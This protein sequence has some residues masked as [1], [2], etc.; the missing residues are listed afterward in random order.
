[1]P[2]HLS[3]EDARMPEN[4]KI[5]AVLRRLDMTER[6]QTDFAKSL[7]TV[8]GDL[9]ELRKP[10][11]ELKTDKA[12]RAERDKNLHER[13]ERMENTIEK[14]LD[15]VKADIDKRFGR[16]AKPVWAAALAFISVLVG[17]VATFIIKGGLNV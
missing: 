6:N 5:D 11:D 14:G 10:L 4:E 1:M 7:T 2:Y 16:L 12:V 17:A 15:E 3:A 8:I 9:N 13:L